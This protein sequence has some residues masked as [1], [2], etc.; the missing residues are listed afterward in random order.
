M[1]NPN[2]SFISDS[3]AG[4]TN[5]CE[6]IVLDLYVCFRAHYARSNI[7]NNFVLPRHRLS[8][9]AFSLRALLKWFVDNTMD[10]IRDCISVKS[11]GK[12][13]VGDI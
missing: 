2:S 10:K 7:G 3:E 1:H 5:R 13:G 8:T 4:M 11:V 12:N 6:H 9:Q